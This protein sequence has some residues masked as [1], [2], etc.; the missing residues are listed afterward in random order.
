MVGQKLICNA[1]HR[2][3]LVLSPPSALSLLL[4]NPGKT[5]RRKTVCLSVSKQE[6]RKTPSSL[7]CDYISGWMTSHA[8]LGESLAA[9]VFL[10]GHPN[11]W[12]DSTNICG[13]DRMVLPLFL[14]VALFLYIPACLLR[15]VQLLTLVHGAKTTVMIDLRWHQALQPSVLSDM[16]LCSKCLG[17]TVPSPCKS[18]EFMTTRCSQTKHEEREKALIIFF[19][20]IFGSIHLIS[21]FEFSYCV[22]F[23]VHSPSTPSMR[24]KDD[25]FSLWSLRISSFL[26]M[27][28]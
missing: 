7:S 6:K 12:T 18:Q 27:R 13:K 11:S 14:Q 15:R 25:C 17:T 8:S 21:S 20:S 24:A 22:C 19:N 3:T 5:G 1:T 26:D 16:C 23:Q 28:H 4:C 9:P 10:C 2:R